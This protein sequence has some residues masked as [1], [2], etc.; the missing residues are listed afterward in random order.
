MFIIYNLILISLETKEVN[1]GIVQTKLLKRE[2]LITAAA[3]Q[4]V[5]G[6]KIDSRHVL[7]YTTSNTW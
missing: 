1:V 3:W 5:A 7:D 6:S 2:W 4:K